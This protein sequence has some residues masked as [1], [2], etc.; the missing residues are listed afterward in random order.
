[1]L[2]FEPVL[3]AIKT[4]PQFINKLMNPREDIWRRIYSGEVEDRLSLILKYSEMHVCVNE[5]RGKAI[6]PDQAM[7]GWRWWS[8][9]AEQLLKQN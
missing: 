8:V 2:W 3:A 7:T 6:R 1:M 5:R 9:L 4:I